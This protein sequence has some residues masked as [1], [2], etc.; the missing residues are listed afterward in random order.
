[1]KIDGVSYR[2]IWLAEDGWSVHIFDQRQLPWRIEIVTL[3]TVNDAARAIKEMWTRGAPL[4]AMTAAYGLCLALRVDASDRALEVAYQQLLIT[5]PT[6]VNLRWA[7]DTMR[8]AV[9]V[10]PETQRVAAA[11]H[12]ASALCEEDI[13]INR[14]IGNYGLSLIQAIAAR[15]SG[16]PVNILMHCNP[17]WLATVDFGTAT[18]PIYLA[19]DQGLPVHVWVDETRPRNQGALTAFELAQHGVPHTVITD[20]AGGLLMQQGKVDL[21]LVGADRVTRNGD[22]A[23]KIGTYL[24]ALAAYDNSVPFYV[25]V[26]YTTFDAGLE[27]GAQIPIEGRAAEEVNAIQGKAQDGVLTTVRLTDSPVFNPGFDI[28]PARLVTG[29]ITDQGILSDARTIIKSLSSK[30]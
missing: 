7:L 19:H 12:R 20:N 2:S 28:T 3:Q 15:K 17:G 1:M 4:L 25:A 27:T 10:L 26:P 11:Y 16:L 8:A 5:R 24:K 23:N 18:A 14:A 29:Y 13:A 9:A 6:A 21:C 22:V 30:S